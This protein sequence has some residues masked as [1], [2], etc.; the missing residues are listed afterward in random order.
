MELLEIYKCDVCGNV[1]EITHSGGGDIVCCSESMKKLSQ[2]LATEENPHFAHIEK[3]D[4]GYKI[5][6]NHPMTQAHHIE[7]I[8][9]ISNDKKYIK[10]KFLKFDEIPELEIKCNCTE[11]FYVRLYCNLDGVWITKN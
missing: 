8:E 9:A 1:I 5:K 2:T 6:F 3:I 4:T 7:Y 10:R 11:G